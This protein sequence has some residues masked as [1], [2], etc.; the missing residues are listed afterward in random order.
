MTLNFQIIESHYRGHNVVINNYVLFVQIYIL[1][2]RKFQKNHPPSNNCKKLY[3]HGAPIVLYYIRCSMINLKD[4]KYG[5]LV[6]T[7]K[8]SKNVNIRIN[9]CGLS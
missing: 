7:V 2:H 4:R 8:I 1:M 5:I 6:R 3:H 9:A